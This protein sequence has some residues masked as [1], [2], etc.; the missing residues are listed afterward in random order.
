[1]V[2]ICSAAII[3]IPI[4][5]CI[6]CVCDGIRLQIRHLDRIANSLFHISGDIEKIKR[7]EK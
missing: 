4:C 6:C 3:V 5:V 2:Y 1:M 7:G